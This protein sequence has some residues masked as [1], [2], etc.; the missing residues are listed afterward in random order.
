MIV[1]HAKSDWDDH[2]LSDFD[3]TLSHRGEKDAPEMAKR[4]LKKDIIPEYIVSSP[5][6]RAKTTAKIFAKTLD[7]AKPEYNESIY[8]AD[9]STLLSVVNG[10]P[11]DYDFVAIFGHN[12][13][14]S[15]LLY[16]LTH[17]M[18][19]MQTCAVAVISFDFDSWKM[20]S[21]DTG[22]LKYYDYPKKDD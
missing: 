16:G 19:D 8:E 5:A 17:K 6:L 9:Y 7:L 18:H 1:R 11:D 13:G 10:L 14:L 2:N 22:T 12:P 4:L 15:Q 21:G 3:R 20:V